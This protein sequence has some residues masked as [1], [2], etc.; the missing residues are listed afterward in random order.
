MRNLQL[1][2]AGALALVMAAPALAAQDGKRGGYDSAEPMARADVM[3][4]ADERF[5]KIDA[6]NDGVIDAAEMAAHREKM[7]AARAERLASM[8]EEDKAKMQAKMQERRGMMKQRWAKR[9]GAADGARTARG[10]GGWQAKLDA[11]G[12]GLISREEFA[13]PML[14]RFDR[15]DANNDGIV[16]PE[17]RAAARAARKAARS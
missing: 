8:S 10:K 11:N 12:D 4:K 6:N 15:M 7:R 16:T 2:T 17:E 3:A 5:A 1:L 9:G 14:R 13:A